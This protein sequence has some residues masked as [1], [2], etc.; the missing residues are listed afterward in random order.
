MSQKIIAVDYDGTLCENAYPDIGDPK[1]DVI[2]YIIEEKAKGS[3]IIL[4]TCRTDQYLENA[5]EWCRQ[6]GIEFDAVNDNIQEIKDKYQ[7]CS[8]K[9]F[10]NIYIDDKSI[11]PLYLKK[12]FKEAIRKIYNMLINW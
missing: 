8:R 4:W 12:G 1:Y 5:L 6:Y 10:A 9:I 11:H 2:N 3:K 7:N